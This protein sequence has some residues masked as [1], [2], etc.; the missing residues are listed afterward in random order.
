MT[1]HTIVLAFGTRPE[2]TKMAPVYRAIEAFPGLRPMILSTG[3]QRQMLDGALNV[4]GLTPD[5]DLNVMTERQ[6]LAGLTAR[7]VP[8]AGRTLKEMGA[9]MVLVHGDTTT[10]FCVAL[11]AFYEGIPVGHV[12]A[13]LRS[14]SLAE[15][16]PEEANRRLTGVLTTLD[17][18]PTPGSKAN[19]LREGKAP[20]GI[21]VTGQTA[22]DAV[23]EVAGRVPLRPEWRARAE[24]GQRL[25]T[26]TMH[27]RENQPMMRDM[28]AALGRVAAAHPDTHFIYP[29]HLSPAVQEAVRPELGHVPNFELV[30]P[31]DYSDMAPLMAASVLLATDSGGLQE[32]GAA[33]GVPVAVL[34][35]VTERPEGLEAGVLT[36][37]GNDPQRLEGVLNDLL[38]TPATLDAMRRARNPYGDGHASQRIAQAIAWHF[39][40]AERPA[41]WS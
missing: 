39:G 10:S 4:F 14:G 15:P 13:G 9:D 8:E 33:L 23:R 16:F 12:E 27:R 38:S 2:A 26:V 6:T 18:S 5:R 17:F 31:L 24:A 25:V 1:D 30:D 28:A 40:S 19:L 36:L 34:R 41:D 21:V 3:Q 35:N 11:S 37:A 20:G 22:V 7:I 29:V 32:E